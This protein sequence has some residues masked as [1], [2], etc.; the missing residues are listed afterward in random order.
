MTERLRT[1]YAS[2]DWT[3]FLALIPIFCAGLVTMAS[4]TGQEGFFNRQLIWI[5][6]AL[7]VLFGVSFLDVRFLRRTSVL[8]ALYGVSCAALIALFALGHTSR[9][10]RSW[11]NLGFFS[12]QPSDPLKIILILMLAKYFSKRHIEIANIRHIIVSGI[13]AIV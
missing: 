8:V 1:L 6:V 12:I 7:A 4:F 5:A 3:L 2:I 11:V 13:Y 10:A 9:G